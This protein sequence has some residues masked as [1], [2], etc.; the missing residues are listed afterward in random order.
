MVSG[1]WESVISAGYEAFTFLRQAY[2]GDVRKREGKVE[3][4]QEVSRLI[5]EVH[6]T[7]FYT[8]GFFLGQRILRTKIRMTRLFCLSIRYI[9]ILDTLFF[10][11]FF[12]LH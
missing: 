7:S 5:R 4:W 9:Q 3:L 10:I 2:S 1:G 8:C 11:W 12:L 6:C